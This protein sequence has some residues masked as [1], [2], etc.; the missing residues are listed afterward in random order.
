MLHNAF[1]IYKKY[2]VR[3]VTIKGKKYKLWIANTPEK[4]RK[5]LSLIKQLPSGWGMFFYFDND[6]DNG[7]TMEKTS[8]P[9]TIIF[10]DKDYKI[11]KSFKCKPRQKGLIYPGKK[12]RYVIEI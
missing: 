11:I 7:F 1:K 4:R 2:K 8:V 9:L 3:P 10:L 6:V 12:Y 5:G